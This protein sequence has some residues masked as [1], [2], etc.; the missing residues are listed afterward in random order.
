MLEE[1]EK[2]PD[3]VVCSETWKIHCLNLYAIEGYV[4]ISDT[5]DTSKADGILVYVRDDL[6]TSVESVCIGGVTAIEVLI[7]NIQPKLLLTSVYRPHTNKKEEFIHSLRTYVAKKNTNNRV[8]M[9][10]GDVNID[11]IKPSIDS[12]NYINVLCEFGFK[13]YINEITRPNPRGSGSC[14]DHIFLKADDDICHAS[15]IQENLTDHYLIM[16]DVDI[17]RTNYPEKEEKMYVHIPSVRTLSQK[18]NWLELLD[19]FDVNECNALFIQRIQEVI[20]KS[21][22]K[23]KNH[24]NNLVKRNDWI[25][26]GIMK[27]CITKRRLYKK[28]KESGWDTNLGQIYKAYNKRLSKIIN[29]AKNRH[30]AEKVKKC[31]DNKKLWTLINGKINNKVKKPGI[32]YLVH[33]NKKISEPTEMANIMN[34]FYKGVS[35]DLIKKMEKNTRSGKFREKRV[36]N[37]IFLYPTNQE[38]VLKI[39][40]RLK[41]TASGCEWM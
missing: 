27:S 28:Y 8:H 22:R 37:S 23:T 18:I 25:T 35:T 16:A 14:I 17:H 30:D 11:T 10:I 34:A 38:E 19:I 13:S 31:T 24:S 9:I 7:H 12:E 33:N 3:I 40:S 41:D 4:L 32:E 36:N 39:I 1:F 6:N 21:R 15:I 2:R 20:E 5:S 26:P 29:Q